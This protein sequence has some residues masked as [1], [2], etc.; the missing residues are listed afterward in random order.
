[1]PSEHI[2]RM[3]L[4]FAL[5]AFLTGFT[6]SVNTA[7][8]QT[9]V[10]NGPYGGVASVLSVDPTAP[11]TIYAGTFGAGIFKS[12]NG[13]GNWTAINNG[14]LASGF[15]TTNF[16]QNLSIW[17]LA[18]DPLTP[19]TLYAGT[20]DG[21]FK[22]TDGGGNW[23][24]LTMTVSGAVVVE[25]SVDTLAIDPTTPTTIYAGCLAVTGG[26]FK[27]TDGGATWTA[28]S[29]GLPGAPVP[30][31]TALAINPLTPTTLYAV[32]DLEASSA[33]NIL[34]AGHDVFKSTDGG[35]SWTSAS[36]GQSGTIVASLAID[37]ATPTT[38]YVT[39][40][41]TTG[42]GLG[43]FKSTDGAGSWSAVNNGVPPTFIWSVAI[44]SR[45]SNHSLCGGCLRPPI[46]KHR[47][48]G[49]LE[50]RHKPQRPVHK[51]ICLWCKCS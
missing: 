9:W 26:L 6:G 46:Q 7:S 45:D 18:I 32:V 28:V 49:K 33:P 37:P 22:S 10:T 8:G 47:R 4:A 5:V 30:S 51:C 13:G 43:V 3:H 29:S 34:N 35:K 19:T 41:P 48:R 12:T 42:G 14:L 21:L 38:L 16:A 24:F 1:M 17:A 40:R 31:V 27:S 2:S 25:G 23:S 39:L 15:V 50:R 36:T 44:E 20:D 11:N